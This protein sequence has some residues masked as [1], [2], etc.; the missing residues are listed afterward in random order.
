MLKGIETDSYKRRLRANWRRTRFVEAEW[1]VP[2]KY[3]GWL[4]RLGRGMIWNDTMNKIKAVRL[5][6]QR[7]VDDR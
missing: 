7:I 6:S 4:M 5:L 2:K 3:G 1:M